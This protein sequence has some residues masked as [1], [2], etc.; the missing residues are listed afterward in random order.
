MDPFAP[1]QLDRLNILR[2]TMGPERVKTLTGD[3]L[4]RNLVAA[5][6]QHIKLA[7]FIWDLLAT[8]PAHLIQRLIDS[9]TGVGA[10]QA[11][12]HGDIKARQEVAK[13]LAQ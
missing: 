3:K 6:P 13:L 7:E 12:V 9:Q 8:T 1:T 5:T 2:A 4:P 11:A 10:L